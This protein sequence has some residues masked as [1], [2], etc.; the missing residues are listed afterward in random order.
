MYGSMVKT[1]KIEGQVLLTA[2]HLKENSMKE[3]STFVA[4]IR[5]SKEDNGSNK[6]LSSCTKKVQRGNN[7]VIPKKRTRKLPLGRR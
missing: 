2:M 4:T 3:K 5:S 7:V 1:P 6:Y